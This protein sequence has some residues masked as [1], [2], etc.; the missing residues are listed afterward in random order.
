MTLYG[1]VGEQQQARARLE[2]VQG[3]RISVVRTRQPSSR[4]L[5]QNSAIKKNVLTHPPLPFPIYIYTLLV[6]RSLV[7]VNHPSFAPCEKRRRITKETSTKRLHS[8]RVNEPHPVM[9]QQHFT[10]QC[11][12]LSVKKPF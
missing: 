7:R 5:V 12:P 6:E 11:P 9:A 10:A 2:T 1:N 3:S 4:H 8:S